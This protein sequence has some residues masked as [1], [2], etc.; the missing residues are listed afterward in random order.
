MP[1]HTNHFGSPVYVEHDI[2]SATDA[3]IGTIRIT[4]VSV[5]WKPKGAHKFFFGSA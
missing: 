4:P 3:K 1:P 5:K 2:R